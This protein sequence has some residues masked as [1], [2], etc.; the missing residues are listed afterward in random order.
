MIN[1]ANSKLPDSKIYALVRIGIFAFATIVYMKVISPYLWSIVSGQPFVLTNFSDQKYRLDS[2]LT[3]FFITIAIMELAANSKTRLQ[4]VLVAFATY[5]V[6]KFV[7]LISIFMGTFPKLPDPKILYSV[8]TELFSL[9]G[10]SIV[11]QLAATLYPIV[12]G[13]ILA[14]YLVSDN[15]DQII[16]RMSW[17]TCLLLT[18]LL[19]TPFAICWLVVLATGFLFGLAA[20]IPYFLLVPWMMLLKTSALVVFIGIVVLNFR[21]SSNFLFWYSIF[22]A[23]IP[24]LVYFA[25]I[26]FHEEYTN[27]ASLAVFA[28]I[29]IWWRFAVPK[30]LRSGY[31]LE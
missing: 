2:W 14:R 6:G 22:A 19:V 21:T 29:V 5:F 18:L 16:R 8:I 31:V 13:A 30:I 10:K 15:Q 17:K 20:F 9:S 24:A 3:G 23:S 27:L 4:Y 7:Y 1:Q 28:G 11:M 26:Q 25:L 12:V